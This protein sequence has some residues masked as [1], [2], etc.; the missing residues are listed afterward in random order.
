MCYL[1]RDTLPQELESLEKNR[2]LVGNICLIQLVQAFLVIN[3]LSILHSQIN[4]IDVSIFISLNL[5]LQYA[6]KI[7]KSYFRIYNLTCTVCIY[8]RDYLNFWL[9]FGTIHAFGHMHGLSC[10]R[11]FCQY[12]EPHMASPLLVK[13]WTFLKVLNLI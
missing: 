10:P 9:K 12:D 4:T 1:F 2:L 6:V 5:Y 13:A 3:I 11:W 7:C 8:W